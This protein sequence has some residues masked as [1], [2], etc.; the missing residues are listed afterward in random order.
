MGNLLSEPTSQKRSFYAIPTRSTRATT[1]SQVHLSRRDPRL[2]HLLRGT[3]QSHLNTFY[4]THTL[5]VCRSSRVVTHVP[6]Q[7]A[8]CECTTPATRRTAGRTVNVPRAARTGDASGTGTDTAP[9]SPSARRPRPKTSGR[10][11]RDGARRKARTNN[12]TRRLTWMWMRRRRWMRT[13]PRPH[14]CLC[15]SQTL[16][17]LKHLC[18]ASQSAERNVRYVAQHCH[19]QSYFPSS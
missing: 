5:Y 4:S 1:L 19:S 18:V 17:L 12:K 16:G 3:R 2:H 7:N 8:E 13:C 14:L 11:G 10:A 6:G 9:S 15:P